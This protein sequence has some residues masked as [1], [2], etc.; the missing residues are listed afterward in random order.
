LRFVFPTDV[1]IRF[2]RQSSK[3][4][5]D[6]TDSCRIVRVMEMGAKKGRAACAAI[7]PVSRP[8]STANAG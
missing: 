1:Q 4:I 8:K 2:R 5:D 3:N 6:L 7:R